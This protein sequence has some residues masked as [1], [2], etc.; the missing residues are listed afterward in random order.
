MGRSQRKLNV[1]WD[2]Y[3]VLSYCII[4]VDPERFHQVSKR[5]ITQLTLYIIVLLE[6]LTVA[7]GVKKFPTFYKPIFFITAFTATHHWSYDQSDE[8]SA[9]RNIRSVWTQF[10]LAVQRLLLPNGL[11]LSDVLS[12]ILHTLLILSMHATCPPILFALI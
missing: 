4:Y 9:H 7:H 12:K 11:L 8:F 5:I 6:K 3:A 2:Q 10:N 1:F